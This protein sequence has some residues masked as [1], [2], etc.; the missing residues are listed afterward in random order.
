MRDYSKTEIRDPS[1]HRTPSQIKEMDETYNKKFQSRIVAR[2]KARRHFIA[3]GKV[4]VGDKKDVGHKHA[5]ALGGSNDPSNWRVE[6]QRG[7]RDWRKDG[8][9]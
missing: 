5:L 2:H 1:S 6:T 3:D 9:K 4:K 7:N 8:L